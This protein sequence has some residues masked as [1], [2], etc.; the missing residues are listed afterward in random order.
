LQRELV[1]EKLK[2]AQMKILKVLQ[3]AGG[4]MG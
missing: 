3:M 2:G 4:D 1:K